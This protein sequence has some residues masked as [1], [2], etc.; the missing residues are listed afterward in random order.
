[1]KSILIN[2]LFEQINDAFNVSDWKKVEKLAGE[3]I[4]EAQYLRL[5][6]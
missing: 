2:Q 3:I 5:D 6:E 1:M 4:V